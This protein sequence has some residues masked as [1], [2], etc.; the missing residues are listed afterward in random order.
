MARRGL[1][2]LGWA[3]PGV[4]SL[5]VAS[6]DGRGTGQVVVDRTAVEW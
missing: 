6:P 3:R 2:W 1:A 5:L 4:V